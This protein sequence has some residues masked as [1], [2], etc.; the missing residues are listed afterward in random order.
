M[1]IDWLRWVISG[2]AATLAMTTLSSLAEGL[3]LTRMNIPWLLGSM[4]TEDRD[5]AK[6]LGTGLHFLN[7]W[8]FSLVYVVFLELWGAT[9]WRGLLLGLF[10]SIVVLSVLLPTL[11]VA[12]P[13]MAGTR[14]APTDGRRLEPPGFFAL[15][16]GYQT[17][18]AVM[19][20]HAA[21]GAVMGWLY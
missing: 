21:F 3:H 8:A 11:P 15:H 16:Y 18:L 10:H 2:F 13:R 12:H 9:W 14:A 5:H 17:P 1:N 7:G 20:S 6:V 19:V 4:V